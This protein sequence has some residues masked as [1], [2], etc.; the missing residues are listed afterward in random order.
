[1][2]AG[3]YLLATAFF[4]LFAGLRKPVAAEAGPTPSRDPLVQMALTGRS[5][6]LVI[7]IEYRVRDVDARK[8]YQAMRFVRQS[9]ERNGAYATTLMRDISNPEIWVEKFVYATWNDY[10]RSRDRP[11][12]EDRLYR[13]SAVAFHAGDDPPR[14]RRYLERPTGS[15]RWRED[16]WDPGVTLPV[17]VSLTTL[18]SH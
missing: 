5:G 12:A 7:E 6:P 1:V 16:T 10:L 8:F 18:G 3:T 2:A 13:D 15:V 17:P 9:R 11:T 14:V 4:G